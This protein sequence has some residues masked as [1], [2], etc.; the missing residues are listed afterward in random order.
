MTGTITSDLSGGMARRALHVVPLMGNITTFEPDRGGLGDHRAVRRGFIAVKDQVAF[1]KKTECL[2]E[3]LDSLPM[4][5]PRG[6]DQA[7]SI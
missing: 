7:A 5:F 1:H 2:P 4:E 3:I 6:G